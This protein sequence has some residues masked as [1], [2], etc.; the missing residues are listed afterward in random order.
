[1]QEAWL[2][3]KAEEGKVR[4][5][6]CHHH[7]RIDNG[8]RG[9]CGV[10]ENRQGRLYSLVYGRP[11]AL[12]VD[13]IEKKPLYHFLPGSSSFS[14][15]TVGC[16]FRCRFCQ[17]ADISQVRGKNGLPGRA[18]DPEEIVT[19]AVETG[20]RS[21]SYTYTEPTVF[22]EYALDIAR[23]ADARG[24][25]NVFV[26][27]GYMTEELLEVFHPHLHAAN[28]DLKAFEDAFYRTY[29]GAR[30]EPVLQ[31]LRAMK[32]MGLWVEVTTLLIPTLNDGEAP[33]RQLTQFLV[34]ALVP[35]TPWHVSR[36]HPTYRLTDLPITPTET[37]MRAYRIGKDAGL[38]YIY[39]GNV[40]GH[41]GEKTFCPGCG[42]LLL[43]RFGFTVLENHLSEGRCPNCQTAISGVWR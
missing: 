34:Q 23:L 17:N 41:A 24:L 36:F 15:A 28:V 25:K 22:F 20:C 2:Y 35:E 14:L 6:A 3:D 1:M 12:H 43:N 37:L 40:P 42:R 29:C 8:K 13:P 33:L 21:I 19:S 11:V 32:K 39:I 10:R 27:N 18:V 38:Q 26:T 16:N 4:C 7:C 5:R 30:L 9:L 31:T